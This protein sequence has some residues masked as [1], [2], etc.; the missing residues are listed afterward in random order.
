QPKKP[1]RPRKDGTPYPE[2][3]EPRSRKL[4]RLRERVVLYDAIIQSINSVK[5]LRG[6]LRDPFFVEEL[7]GKVA[8]FR[9]LKC[10][11]IAYSHSLLDGHLNALA[12]LQRGS[13]LLSSTK[14]TYDS[15]EVDAAPTLDL[16]SSSL[17]TARK[18]VSALLSRTHAL[19]E[20]HKQEANARA[21]A[22]KNMTSAL[23]LVQNL[24]AHP[25]PGVQVDLKS[26][27]QYP[28]KL[29]PVP[30]KPLF[31]DVSWNYIDYPGREK[32]GLAKSATPAD[33]PMVNGSEK[34]EDQPKKRGWFGFGR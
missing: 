14:S 31:P 12:L 23:P 11:T 19:V 16:S 5:D 34:E 27:V 2:K 9:A 33:E 28:P 7:D 6:A 24:N 4:A 20:M 17:D 10:L 1:K 30:V 13:S 26:L 18:H 29:Q 22:S 3:E 25:A 8:F 32:K 15:A 21:A